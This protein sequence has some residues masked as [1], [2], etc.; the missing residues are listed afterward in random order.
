MDNSGA[1]SHQLGT[2]DEFPKGIDGV[3]VFLSSLRKTDCNWG[4]P[5]WKDSMRL[6][7]KA[8]ASTVDDPLPSLTSDSTKTGPSEDQLG[9]P[10]V[11]PNRASRDFSF[12]YYDTQIEKPPC[13]THHLV[14]QLTERNVKQ[15]EI[16]DASAI[17]FQLQEISEQLGQG[18]I[19]E[20]VG[21]SQVQPIHQPNIHHIPTLFA[22]T[23]R[24]ATDYTTF[25]PA[26][27]FSVPYI[28]GQIS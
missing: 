28:S 10:N 13:Q 17:P 19:A 6:K 9:A 23:D 21:S 8:T 14:Q 16:L 24:R 20:G 26:D 1:E 18:N 4:T 3:Q 11:V 27:H 22:S 5:E 2:S 12:Y 15:S 7:T 25:T